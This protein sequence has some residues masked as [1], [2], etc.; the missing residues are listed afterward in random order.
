MEYPRRSI[1]SHYTTKQNLLK[2]KN[3]VITTNNSAT[4]LGFVTLLSQGAARISVKSWIREGA[5]MAEGKLFNC[6]SCGAALEPQVNQAAI[7][8]GYCG[9]TVSI[10]EELRKTVVTVSPEARRWI[11][12]SIWGFVILMVI[13][14]VVPFL[15]SMCAMIAGIGGSV[16]PFFIK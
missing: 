5:R 9:N 15:C 3:R 2:V 10:P 13:T 11:K 16:L 6:P 4:A 8:C 12:I 7:N 14:L 1:E